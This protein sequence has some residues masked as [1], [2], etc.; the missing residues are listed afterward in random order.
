MLRGSTTVYIYKSIQ[1]FSIT[2]R[3]LLILQIYFVNLSKKPSIYNSRLE[4]LQY[5]FIHHLIEKMVWWWNYVKFM[6]EFVENFCPK[7]P[8]I[9]HQKHTSILIPSPLPTNCWIW[10]LYKFENFHV[11]GL[12]IK[13]IMISHRHHAVKC[14]HR[15]HLHWYKRGGIM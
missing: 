15:S 1:W 5:Q 7:F 3:F 14:S 2:K 10:I 13:N 11:D 6:R 4:M 12:I 8:Y 9:D